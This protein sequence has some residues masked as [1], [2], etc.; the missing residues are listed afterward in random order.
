[1]KR[2]VNTVHGYMYWF[3]GSVGTNNLAG[4]T[5]DWKSKCPASRICKIR[6]LECYVRSAATQC[7]HA[8]LPVREKDTHE[9]AQLLKFQAMGGSAQSPDS[10]GG[11]PSASTKQ[12][13]KMKKRPT[14]S[15]LVAVSMTDEP[16]LSCAFAVSQRGP[17]TEVL[18]D[19]GC[20]KSM[21]SSEAM[22]KFRYNVVREGSEQ[23][24][25][26]AGGG[27]SMKSAGKCRVP[28]PSLGVDTYFDSADCPKSGGQTP[29]LPGIHTQCRGK[30]ILVT[31][32]S[33]ALMKRVDGVYVWIDLRVGP[34]GHQFSD[35]VSPGK[36]AD[37]ELTLRE[38]L[39]GKTC[40]TSSSHPPNQTSA[41]SGHQCSTHRGATS[42][43]RGLWRG[44]IRA[45]GSGGRRDWQ[46][47]NQGRSPGV[48]HRIM[49][50]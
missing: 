2:G 12:K 38:M 35:I 3:E 9:I 20:G 45:K 37:L 41:A 10:A 23:M 6:M 36:P 1:M 49:A 47:E 34:G 5:G 46:C 13:K 43:S 19:G 22:S 25:R 30:F 42:A 26:F 40:S 15:T 27:K 7:L 17:P 32:Q 4:G 39:E 24:F 8:L 11:Q 16:E 44:G 31:H 14:E 48:I 28:L 21:G 33:R 50:Y 18:I 29:L